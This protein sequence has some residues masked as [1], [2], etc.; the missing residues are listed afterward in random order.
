MNSFHRWFC[1]T[2]YWRKALA[3]QIM[4][5][6][7]DGVALG[8]D[9]LEVGPGPGLATDV[10]RARHQRVT[11]IEIDPLLA[12]SLRHCLQGTNVKGRVL[13]VMMPARV[14]PILLI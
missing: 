12:D 2:D 5:S 9:V 4:P 1:R 8:E 6:A 10:L 7:L 14:R 3:Q 11:S 13:K